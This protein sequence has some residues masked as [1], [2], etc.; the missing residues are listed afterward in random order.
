MQND[1]AFARQ[2]LRAGA[3]GHVPKEAAGVEL[4]QAVRAAAPGRTY[5][6]PERGARI[7]ARIQQKLRR[8]PSWSATRWTMR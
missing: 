5:L 2:A 4:V 6:N 8:A 3:L 1:P 7:A